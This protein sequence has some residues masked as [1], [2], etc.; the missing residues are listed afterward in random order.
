MAMPKR[1]QARLEA[2]KGQ[3]RSAL[4]LHDVPSN[5]E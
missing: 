5:I 3:E 1:G 4:F 2:K